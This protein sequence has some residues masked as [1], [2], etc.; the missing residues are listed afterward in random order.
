M[1]GWC[2]AIEPESAESA[3]RAVL[4]V[5]RLSVVANPDPGELVRRVVGLRRLVDDVD[6]VAASMVEE[7]LSRNLGRAR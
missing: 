4:D 7:L 6:A 3:Y 5:H 1:Q 2:E